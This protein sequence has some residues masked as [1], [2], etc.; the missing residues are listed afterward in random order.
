[1]LAVSRGH[2]WQAPTAT[3]IDLAQHSGGQQCVI[4]HNPH[5]PKIVAA[6]TK[7][8]GNAAAGQK[9]AEDCAGFHGAKGQGP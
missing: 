7:V 5:A 2:A 6:A 9:R 8:A 1:M 4:C 3:K